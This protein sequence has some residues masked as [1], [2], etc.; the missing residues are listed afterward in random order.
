[1]LQGRLSTFVS[2]ICIKRLN[3][4][5]SVSNISFTRTHQNGAVSVIVN[6]QEMAISGAIHFWGHES[7]K[8]CSFWGQNGQQI[9]SGSL[10]PSMKKLQT[11][12]AF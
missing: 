3:T 10:E 7:P 1:M 4:Q 2:T 6:F 9:L 5:E 11:G 12:A 8:Y